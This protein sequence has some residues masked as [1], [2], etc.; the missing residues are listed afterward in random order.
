MHFAHRTSPLAP[1]VA[2]SLAA[3]L[4]LTVS[5]S[6]FAEPKVA[7]TKPKPPA[8][9][10]GGTG[11]TA[12]AERLQALEKPNEKPYD[13][14]DVSEDPQKRYYFVGARYR[15]S[16]LPAFLLAPFMN[17][18]RSFYFN[19][20]GI[21]ADLRKDGF[22]FIPALSFSEYGTGD[23]LFADK[24]RDNNL[25]Q[26]W[27]LVRSSLKAIYFSV[28]ILWSVPVDRMIDFEYGLGAGLGFV[29]GDLMTNWVHRDAN[30]KY[31]SQDG[32]QHFT[33]CQTESDGEGCA[34]R[35]H[36]N[37]TPARVGGYSEPSWLS[38]GSKPSVLPYLSIPQF[39][40]R[41]KPSKQF[42]ARVGLGFS[43]TGFWFG[44]SGNYGLEEPKPTEPRPR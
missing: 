39:G 12:A 33:P 10:V 32:S 2:L 17:E 35:D 5:R 30:G 20:V 36:S 28:D 31:T 6:A 43:A 34:P 38:G 40:L 29:F 42:Q 14:T 13:P 11:V 16:L 27:T 24:S 8:L 19:T 3:F 4:P 26:N 9:R 7:D 41:I 44:L 21:E 23:V 22:S 1:L 15:G 25:A 18:A 37:S